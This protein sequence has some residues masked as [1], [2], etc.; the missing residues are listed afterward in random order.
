MFFPEESQ[1]RP[2]RL[3]CL[4]SA[5]LIC[6]SGCMG[7]PGRT[8]PM[9]KEVRQKYIE[10]FDI[11]TKKIE[12][13]FWDPEILESRW[14]GLKEECSEKVVAA[15]GI[16]EARAAM[17]QLLSALK[18]SHF[19]LMSATASE[20]FRRG[21]QP[22]EAGMIL[23]TSDDDQV[24]V[25]RV[26]PNGPA[27][28]AGIQPGDEILQA[29]DRELASLIKEWKITGNRYLVVQ[30]LRSICSGKA[31]ATRELLVLGESGERKVTIILEA[32]DKDI[33]RVGV[34][35]ISP[36]P[37]RMEKKI[38]EDNILY[39][40]WN[41][42]L[43]PGLVMPW[44]EESLSEHSE[45]KGLVIDLRGNPG[46]IGI[47]ACGISGWLI[48]EQGFQL[49]KM[50]MR[51]SEL[52]FTVNPRMGGWVKPVAM[53]IDE[54]SGST[55]EIMAQGLRDAGRVRLFGRTTAGA[56]LPSLII[57]L[58]SGDM[59][60]YAISDYIS[61]SGHRMEGVGVQPDERIPVD[62]ALIRKY[63]DPVLHRARNW[64]VG[65]P[66]GPDSPQR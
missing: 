19:G 65:K 51:D 12:D 53:L 52:N 31:G 63:G 59:L 25:V 24:I 20:E 48:P 18:L 36:I 38:L 33:P 62:S 6:V 3:L 30:G 45:A 54:G 4:L 39:L 23:R 37:L 47:M 42:F 44:I 34:G 2:Y 43:G 66:G 64:L 17:R 14:D 29:K 16:D 50:I 61:A 26:E 41:M 13:S 21:R 8:P 10:S 57:E 15:E 46:G 27:D 60:Q 58:P 11:M 56:A 7:L 1:V 49:G 55:S 28:I 40:R 35:N 9:T 22:G 32:A 5:L